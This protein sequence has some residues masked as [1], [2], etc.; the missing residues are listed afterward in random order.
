MMAACALVAMS[1]QAQ[2]A[3]TTKAKPSSKPVPRML[4]LDKAYFA[5]RLVKFHSVPSVSH[6]HALV[7]GPWNLGEKITPGNND[8]RPNL[9]FVSP[10]KL[11]RADGHPDFDHNEVLSAL[12]EEV[13]NFD[14]YWV[15]VLDP[16]V[17]EEF[18]S[19]QQII[20]AT[21]KTFTPPTGF[22]FDQIPSAG[23]LR[24]FLKVK[25]LAGLE[26]FNRPDGDLPRVAV[27]PARFTVRAIAEEMP[28][29]QKSVEQ[30]S[31]S[32]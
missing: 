13:S 4:H 14:V 26:K 1:A 2:T 20:M 24:T 16:T 32:N 7:V 30:A 23:F 9:Y 17:G 18:T 27:I 8:F 22:T 15:M 19:E 3:S 10:G 6:G 25:D 5:G 12:P 29:D 21:Q 11:H 28:A 31:D